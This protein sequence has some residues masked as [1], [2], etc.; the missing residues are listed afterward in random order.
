VSAARRDWERALL[1]DDPDYQAW[2]DARNQEA[3][4]YQEREYNGYEQTRKANN[5]GD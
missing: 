5:S 4:E 2:L 3:Q 1:Q